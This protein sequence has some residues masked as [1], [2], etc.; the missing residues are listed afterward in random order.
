MLSP[1]LKFKKCIKHVLFNSITSSSSGPAL[2]WSDT[3][4]PVADVSPGVKSA[5]VCIPKGNEQKP[6]RSSVNK[7]SEI[8]DGDGAAGDR[9]ERL[10]ASGMLNES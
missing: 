9:G 6:I 7:E 1:C 2:L 10:T 3:L 4:S 8:S 5:L